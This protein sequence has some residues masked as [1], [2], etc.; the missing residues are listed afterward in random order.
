MAIG[1]FFRLV[2]ILVQ[3]ITNHTQLK[4]GDFKRFQAVFTSSWQRYARP[5]SL[6][7]S[8]KA[9]TW[10]R[11]ELG[12]P[13]ISCRRIKARQPGGTDHGNSISFLQFSGGLQ[14]LH[15]SGPWKFLCFKLSNMVQQGPTWCKKNE[16]FDMIQASRT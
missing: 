7:V 15:F 6:E 14:F 13:S 8:R 3:I 9:R 1:R 11:T 5:M 16:E 2:H 4:K 12:S 10:P